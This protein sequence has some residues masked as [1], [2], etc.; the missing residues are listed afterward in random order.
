MIACLGSIRRELVVLALVTLLPG[1]AAFLFAHHQSA[2]PPSL[3]GSEDMDGLWIPQTAI[4][5][6]RV[7][8]GGAC[9]QREFT[10]ENRTGHEITV[11][12]VE[13][14]CGCT[15]P[16]AI[17]GELQ[18]GK[19]TKVAVI[20]W[21]PAA[22]ND[23]GG[24]FR[25]TV[26]VVASTINGIKSIPLSLTGFLEPDSSLRVFPVNVDIDASYSPTRQPAILH[27]KGS[28]NLLAGIPD[29]L[30]LTPG[31]DQRVS[32]GNLPAGDFEAIQAKD[33]KVVV[34]PNVGAWDRE[35]W[36]SVIKFT[37][38]QFSDGLT[39]RVRGKGQSVIATPPS[40]IL[41]DDAGGR[42]A[43]VRF[44]S[45][46]ASPLLAESVETDLPLAWNLVRQEPDG[47]GVFTL[48]LDVI[49]S[50]PASTAG[51][52]IVQISSRNIP[53]EI[54]SIPIVILHN[55]PRGTS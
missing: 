35:D 55:D 47:K 32:I 30:F 12:S 10:L 5:L 40:V 20:F 37:P 25:R 6:G 15:V 2:S 24:E 16:T 38:D 33:V 8:S 46:T 49:K 26:T 53:S 1:T 22:A 42:E 34:A 54:I 18:N 7:W 43:T 27:F 44:T 13:S 3:V 28:A 14:D 41:T 29:T 21:P 4:D 19:S 48:Q 11:E 51:T 31:H 9:V 50:L 52:L 23:Q 45:K 17:T 36:V 39:V